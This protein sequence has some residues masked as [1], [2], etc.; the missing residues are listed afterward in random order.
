[1]RGPDQPGPVAETPRMRQIDLGVALVQLNRP[2]EAAHV[3]SLAVGSNWL[4]PSN[5]WRAVELDRAL[6][7]RFGSV[8][9]VQAF[10]ERVEL[11]RRG[12]EPDSP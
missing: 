10:H 9:E 8:A 11:M 3:G 4:V 1:M 7:S 5:Q 2:D 12:V 6:T